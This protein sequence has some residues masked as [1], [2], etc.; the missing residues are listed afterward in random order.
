MSGLSDFNC[1]FNYHLIFTL[2]F[3]LSLWLS[4]LRE[5]TLNVLRTLVTWIRTSSQNLHVAPDIL[6]FFVA[7]NLR[8]S[9][10]IQEYLFISRF[11]IS[12]LRFSKRTTIGMIRWYW[13]VGR[14]VTW[15]LIILNWCLKWRKISMKCVEK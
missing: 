11:T 4:I 15:E 12:Y 8:W 3:L 6:S 2:C 10:N 14:G 1:F 13:Q 7:W 9:F 5:K